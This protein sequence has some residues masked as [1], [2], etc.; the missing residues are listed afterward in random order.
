MSLDGIVVRDPEAATRAHSRIQ[1]DGEH[2]HAAERLY[3]MLNK[4][5]GLVTTVD[6]EQGRE[7]VYRCFASSHLPWLAPVGRLDRASEGLLLFTNDAEWA[8]AL[9]SPL[10][11]VPK[12][13]HVQI[14]GI[15]DPPTLAR[16]TAGVLM[17]EGECLRVRQVQL[18]RAGERNAWLACTLTEGRNRHLRRLLGGVGHPVLRLLRVAVG[19]LVLGDLAKGAWRALSPAEVAQLAPP[20]RP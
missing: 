14:E 4:P 16:L 5:R 10:S 12:T 15:P 20:S 3:V 1:I 6:D 11:H 13:Y 17:P 2:V 19:E 9:L 7:T 8:A 18:L